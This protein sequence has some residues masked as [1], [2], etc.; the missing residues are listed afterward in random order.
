MPPTN[1]LGLHAHKTEIMKSYVPDPMFNDPPQNPRPPKILD[2][3]AFASLI[4]IVTLL[5]F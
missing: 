4:L 5:I 3:L 2:A 1:N